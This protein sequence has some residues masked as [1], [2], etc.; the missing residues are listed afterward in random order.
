MCAFIIVIIHDDVFPDPGLGN[1]TT[2]L[3][4][5]CSTDVTQKVSRIVL[6]LLSS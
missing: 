1:A 2:Q 3:S 4:Q 5:I 6:I